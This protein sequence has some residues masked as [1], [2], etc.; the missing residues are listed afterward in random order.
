MGIGVVVGV[1]VAVGVIVGVTEGVKVSSS[2][3]VGEGVTV[4]HGPS[5]F[6]VGVGVL[7]LLGG[8]GCEG[9]SVAVGFDGGG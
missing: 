2:V 4:Y 5:G 6:C 7:V 8:F 1:M 9:S 3:A